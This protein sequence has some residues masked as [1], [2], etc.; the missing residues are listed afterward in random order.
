MIPLGYRGET[1]FKRRSSLA[2]RAREEGEVKMQ[3]KYMKQTVFL[4]LISVFLPALSWTQSFNASI[5]GTVTDPSGAVVPDARLELTAVAT[6]A[7]AKATSDP[8][9]LFSIANLQPGSYELKAS[10]EGFRDYV[11][12]G[13]SVNMNE[14]VRLDVKLEL[15]LA[16]QSVE[17]TSNVSPL[18]YENAELKQSITPN[19]ILEL[20][21]LVAGTIRSAHTFVPLMPG[22]TTGSG[23]DAG[24]SRI[25]GGLNSGDEAVLDGVTMQEGLMSMS[26]M[27][28]FW[29]YPLSPDSISEISVLA[30]NYEPQ[31]GSTSSAVITAVTKSGTNEFHGGAYEYHRNTALNARQFG[32]GDRPIDLEHDFGAYIGGPAKIP[33]LWSGNRKTYFFVNFEGFRNTGGLTKPV[34]SVPTEL[35]RRGDFSEWP[36]PIY[37]P[38]TTRPD[39]ENPGSYIRD[40][41]MG[42]DGITPNVICPTDPRMV[43]SLAPQWLQW[44]PL[45]NRPGVLYNYEAPTQGTSGAKNSNSWAVR[46]DHHIGDNDRVSAV[47]R[48][49]STVT[50]I[51]SLWP[52][53]IS[54]DNYRS[55]DHN[56]MDRFL[57]DHTFG[58]N[59]LNHLAV[60][61]SNFLS[62][63]LSISDAY[64]D[65]VPAIAGVEA[66]THQPAINV[67]EYGGYGSTLGGMEDHP[68]YTASDLLTTTHGKHTIKL[69]GEFRHVELWRVLDENRSG[70]FNFSSQTTGILET[71]SGNPIASFLLGAV[72]DASARFYSNPR[73]DAVAHTYILHLGDTWKAT[74]RL[75]VSYGIRWDVS[76]PTIEKSDRNSFFD[77][78]GVNLAAGGRLGRLAF[79]GSRWGA[80]SFGRR[81]PEH[82]YYHAFAPRLGIAYA[83][84]PKTVVRTGY[85]I[86]YNQAYYPNWDAGIGQD[87]FNSDI[88]FSSTAGGLEPAFMLSEGFPQNF[89]PPPFIDSGYRNGQG[90]NYRPFD[91]NRLAYT[92]QWNLTIEH[93]LTSD[94][95]ISAGYVGNK[96]TR[97]VSQTAALN[98]LDPR[99]LSMGNQL[100]DEF[101]P[102][103]T[104]V[105]GVPLPYPGWVEQMTGCA[106]SVAQALLPYPQ[107]CTSL[108]GI[109][110]NAGN[111]TYHSFQLKVERRFSRG[112]WLLGSYTISKL[113]TSSDNIQA[114][115][116]SWDAVTGTISP[117]ERQRNKS[118]AVDDVPQV[119][120]LALIYELPFGK[121]HRFLNR[122]GVAD[123]IVGGWELAN[124][125]RLSSATPLM[126]RS[127]AN[128][129][130]QFAA[131]GIPALLPG[132]DPWLQDKGD[133]DPSQPLLNEAAFESANDFNFYWGQGPRISNLRGLPYRNH[134]FSLS[135]TTAITERVGFQIRAEFF[136]V[137][138]WHCF[139]GSA[140]SN[141][142]GSP[143]FGWWNG[144]VSAPRQI[145]VGAR[146]TF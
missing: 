56:W 70:T 58:P 93:Q 50:P 135:K 138:N 109:N 54:Q 25:N 123:K 28:A 24:V 71:T 101:Q 143:D 79:A 83:V 33:L 55:P 139:S 113:L 66:H 62:G 63:T 136:N 140:F 127:W 137:W 89:T 12:R 45:P 15:G 30:S 106:P 19:I 39:P 36:Y 95:Y 76:T 99:Y 35:M 37:D 46:V 43:N 116:Q 102:G 68:I 67:G 88:Y 77:P 52:V 38:A 8:A 73:W 32:A 60:G 26:G 87:G 132:A 145:Q 22:V 21:I 144:R 6:G 107:Y 7:V 141:Y 34:L 126:I 81:A 2:R 10:A 16:T 111:S 110:E 11:Q 1:P 4:V 133:F 17:V 121:G 115:A 3:G 29:D 97:L 74:P 44:V 82:T 108:M 78:E 98:A 94:M 105:D 18:N 20:P 75:S 5:S 118:L 80:A 57:W 120:S 53:Q 96:G 65:A 112:M 85:G 48:Y 100:Y 47:I 146:V 41:F 61:Y 9:G 134:D 42:C 86:F 125:V 14:S 72:G 119:F 131:G 84:S 27:A 91:A 114:P 13:I 104:M 90:L 64:V 124:I 23:N 69:G 129:P 130:G 49:R 128:V 59:A 103:D 117:F 142:I 92:Q 31:Y 122:G 51:Q 40:Q